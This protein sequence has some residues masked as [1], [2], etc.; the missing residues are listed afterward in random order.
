[1]HVRFVRLRCVSATHSK[2]KDSG[3]AGRRNRDGELA[4]QG[5]LSD[6]CQREERPTISAANAAS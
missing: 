5:L 2:R 6:A 3:Q 1:M 4:N